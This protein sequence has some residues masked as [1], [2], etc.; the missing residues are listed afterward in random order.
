MRKLLMFVPLLTQ[1]ACCATCPTIRSTDRCAALSI[2]RAPHLNPGT[3]PDT[4]GNAILITLT[5]DEA[6]AIARYL[7]R[8]AE[9]RGSLD[10]CSL[11]TWRDK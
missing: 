3:A 1:L 10:G 11:I 6:V 2:P 8:V 5:A 7:E 4:S 9:A